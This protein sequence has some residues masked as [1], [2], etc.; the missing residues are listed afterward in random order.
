MKK[1][2][3][4][5]TLFAAAIVAIATYSR[6][7]P[8]IAFAESPQ[9]KD[10][11]NEE[12]AIRELNAAVEAGWNK[13]DAPVLDQAFVKDCEPGNA[14][15]ERISGHDKLVKTHPALFARALRGKCQRL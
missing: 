7:L 6:V 15:G 1:M 10:Q 11:A 2:I 3:F 4:T 14:F 8:K 5:L 13:H 12:R 9:A